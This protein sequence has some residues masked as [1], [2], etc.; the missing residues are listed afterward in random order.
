M[1]RKI[2][3]VTVGTPISPA[4]IE[5][6]LRPVKTVNGV[7]P[8]ESGNVEVDSGGNFDYT[9]YGLPIVY[10]TGDTTGM[11][12]DNAVTLNYVYGERSGTATV[13]WQGSSSLAYPKK[14]Y[15]IKFDNAFEAVEG[16]GVQN[17][18]CLKADWVDFSHCRNVVTAKLWGDIVRS[19][20]T[21]E[22][23]ERLSALPNGG[24]ID[25]FPCFV[26]INDEWQGIYSFT[27]PKDGW[28]MGM[29]NGTKE[30]ILCAEG[31]SFTS[32][33]LFKEEAVLGQH[34]E[35]EYSSD[36][37]AE[38]DIQ[39]SLNRLINAVINSDGTD[40]DTTIAQYVDI[41]S[42][43]DYMILAQ[44][45]Y[46]RDGIA[47]NYLLATYDGVK[48][49]FSAYDLDL[50]WG[51]IYADRAFD[52]AVTSCAEEI[53]ALFNLLLT[54]QFERVRERYDG[55]I[56]GVMGKPLV[57]QKF[58]N[59][60]RKIPRPAYVADAEKWTTVPN[61]GIDHIAQILNWYGE[62]VVWVDDFYAKEDEYTGTDGL[63][64]SDHNCIGIGSCLEKDIT[65]ALYYLGKR[66]TSVTND[67]FAGDTVIESV[68]MQEGSF[69]VR[70]RSFK[71]CT[72]LKNI[73]LPST[74]V[75]INWDAFRNTAL[76]V[77][78]LPPN[79]TKLSGNA[80]RECTGLVKISIPKTITTLSS[81]VFKD[82][83][84]LKDIFYA[85]TMAE[86][87]ALT[88]ETDWNTNTGAYTIHCTDG[89]IAKESV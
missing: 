28:L 12:K 64:Y 57:T 78:K 63:A 88:K 49:F 66:I 21:S 69:Y 41:D 86:W 58:T 60:A 32:A 82:C 20:A 55:L 30:A 6:E 54:Y 3:G 80:F 38:S 73:V 8:D 34:F 29:G 40:I 16:W 75:E 62:R 11:N 19:R 43:I 9:A 2:I 79:L 48:W 13:K 18:Y 45:I 51:E 23:T 4:V 52:N 1:S 44:L 31:T 72:S 35:L 15:T 70:N 84:S 5:E 39:A 17:K 37:F 74:L 50:V 71:D 61:T 67:A 83:T 26:V 42:A 81:S 89:D 10:L 47:K 33:E 14:N 22:L 7:A 56:A 76:K 68:T 53:H 24:A 25:G 46:H 77:V 85:G 27:I 36:G 87:E 59:Y 65:I